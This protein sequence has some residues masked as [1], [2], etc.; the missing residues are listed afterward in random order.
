MK[1]RE[2]RIKNFRCL[3]NVVVPISDTTVLVGENNTGKTA[4]L[5]ALRFALTRSTQARGARPFTEYDY[6]M[7]NAGDSPES[8][9]GII[10]ELWFREDS[11]DEWPDPLVQALAE[12]IQIDPQLDLDS[13]GLRLFSKYDETAKDFN[14]NWEFLTLDGQ[15]VGGRAASPANLARFLL[16][17]RCFYLSSLR[18][19]ETEFSP[20]SRFWGRILR[21][22]KISDEQK[23]A[24]EEELGK[25]N[26]NL[27]KLDP[28]L[29]NIIDTL[30]KVQQITE[31]GI[32]QKTSIQA[33][34][35]KPWDLMS[36]AEIVVQSRGGEIGF[37]LRSHGQG[38]QSLAVLFLFQAYIQVLLKPDF[39]PQTE[40]ILALEEPETHLH[41]QATRALAS[42]LGEVQSQKKL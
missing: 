3:E 22:L 37:P 21:G 7:V 31:I 38:M 33:L 12:I 25:L 16:Y 14:T 2:V 34:P 5:E 18:D 4:F 30:D 26:E 20:R 42:N 19:S 41:P 32:E 9:E 24:L 29:D 17:I 15:P 35:L 13:I 36:K 27:L 8:C 40:A 1:L 28:R 6:H 23:K 11:P 10:I 39:E